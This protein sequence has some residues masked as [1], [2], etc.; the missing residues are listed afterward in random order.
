MLGRLTKGGIANPT[1]A[2]ALFTDSIEKTHSLLVS[3]IW[4]DDLVSDELV[5]A[6]LK[7]GEDISFVRSILMDTELRA[8]H[9]RIKT[10]ANVYQVCLN[11]DPNAPHLNQVMT[12]TMALLKKNRMTV[13]AIPK[14]L[15]EHYAQQMEFAIQNWN[16]EE[17]VAEEE[18]EEGDDDDD[19]D[20]Q[21]EKEDDNDAIVDD[22]FSAWASRLPEST[23]T[24]S[25]TWYRSVWY[26]VNMAR[27][28]G[29]YHERLF[30]RNKIVDEQIDRFV[31]AHLAVIQYLDSLANPSDDAICVET[32][33]ALYTGLGRSRYRDDWPLIGVSKKE[34]AVKETPLEILTARYPTLE[35]TVES[36][37]ALLNRDASLRPANLI[38]GYWTPCPDAH[39]ETHVLYFSSIFILNQCRR[40]IDDAATEGRV[41]DALWT[42]YAA[43]TDV[44]FHG[45]PHGMSDSFLLTPMKTKSIRHGPKVYSD[46]L[47]PWEAF[48]SNLNVRAFHAGDLPDLY[49]ML[50][51]MPLWGKQYVSPTPIGQIYQKSLPF[52]CQRRLLIQRIVRTIETD[53]A[54]AVIFGRLFWTMLA[55]LYPGDMGIQENTHLGMRDLLRIKELTDSKEL[56]IGAMTADQ[57]GFAKKTATAQSASGG[58]LLVFVALRLHIIYMARLNPLY[59]STAKNCIDWTYFEQTTIEMANVIRGTPLFSQDPFGQARELLGKAVKSTASKVHRLRHNLMAQTLADYFNETLE[60]CII[61]DKFNREADVEKLQE[62]QRI[63]DSRERFQRVK[64]E[65]EA[66]GFADRVTMDNFDSIVN[67]RMAIDTESLCAYKSVLDFPCRSRITNSLCNLSPSE[68]ISVKGISMLAARETGDVSLEAFDII[69]SLME[70]YKNNAVP[71]MFRECIDRFSMKDFV[72][73]TYYFNMVALLDNIRFSPLDADTI[74]RSCESM[75]RNHYYSPTLPTDAFDI[76]FSL[77]CQRVCTLKGAHKYGAKSVAYDL[78]RQCYV[79]THQK[80]SRTSDDTESDPS[81][82]VDTLFSDDTV[83]DAARQKGRGTKK[84]AEMTTRKAIRNERKTFIRVPCHQPLLKISLYGRALIWKETTQ[85]MFCPKCASLHEYSLVDFS[86]QV[87]YQCSECVQKEATHLHMRTCA[88]CQ[89]SNQTQVTANHK[90]RIMLNTSRTIEE[91]LVWMYF[92]KTHYQ[93]AKVY[94]ENCAKELLWKLIEKKEHDAMIRNA[95]KH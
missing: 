44:F 67:Q 65:M 95:Q 58:S 90:L 2:T 26:R 31:Q 30:G 81:A 39:Y 7:R 41:R 16:R 20:D 68:R 14:T 84:T 60:K 66:A 8:N 82:V 89:K 3:T 56:L 85:F 22:S 32:L 52:A 63:A 49:H 86:G 72:A 10:V 64:T 73:V 83:T 11:L 70:I 15:E 43:F 21:D 55:G 79:C 94:S 54:V 61:K 36:V 57:T 92:C 78:E 34:F 33:N 88:Y 6:C 74:E 71:K 50:V 45:V 51:P 9:D 93:Y 19:D 91:S 27:V 46:F 4:S 37:S 47:T 75:R 87:A 76:Y 42:Y 28:F 69:E 17:S 13:D 29:K 25:Y 24:R 62:I 40:L 12:S 59:I 48:G 38:D 5:L 23:S 53:E 77:C 80:V 35:W 1:L 18:E